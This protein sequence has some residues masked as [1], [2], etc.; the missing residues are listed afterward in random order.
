[1][2]TASTAVIGSDVFQPWITTWPALLSTAPMTRLWPTARISS[3]ANPVWMYCAR[4][5]PA[6]APRYSDE[7]TITWV[8]PASMSSTA[9]AADR[10]PPPTRH[11]SFAAM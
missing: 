8:A 1:M 6:R 11:G 7:P 10:T 4:L 5:S 9:R 2:R 3:C